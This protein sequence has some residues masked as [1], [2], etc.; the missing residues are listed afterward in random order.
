MSDAK[1]YTGGCHCGAV[2]YTAKI[3]LST[4]ME[5]NCSLCR[6]RGW[7][8]TFVP[9]EDF[10]LERG[11]EALTEYRFH[12]KLIR[13]LCCRVCG[14]QSFGRGEAPGGKA[15]VAV[16]VRCLDGVD[17]SSLPVKQVDGASL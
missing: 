3:A 7:L 2:R 11:E 17:V 4:V 15:M 13:H 6:R 12:K 8:L 5:C 14:V 10:T 16:N 1:T 9:A